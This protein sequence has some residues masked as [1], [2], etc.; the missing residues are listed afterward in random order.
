MEIQ[1]HLKQI[2]NFALIL[3][4]ISLTGCR[5]ENFVEPP[6]PFQNQELE[7]N[8]NIIILGQGNEAIRL[9][10]NRANVIQTDN[11]L[12]IKGTLFVENEKYGDMPFSTGDFELIKNSTQLEK[13]GAN[14]FYTKISGFSKVELPHEGL[15]K[16]LLMSGMPVAPLGYKKGSEFDLGAFSWPV[17]PDRYYFYYENPNNNPYNANI[18]NSSFKN[19]QKIAIDPTDPYT[20]FTCD[21][22]GTKIGDLQNVG[23]AVSTQGLIPFEP[24]VTFGGIKGF[25]GSLYFTGT[26]PLK[27][28]PVSLTGEACLAFNSDDPEGFNKFFKGD[29]ADFKLGLNGKATFDHEALDWLNVEVVLGKSTLTLDVN[30]SGKTELKFAGEREFPP[31]SPSDFLYEIIGQD[32]DFLD[33][34]SPIEQKE[35]F[36]GTIGTEL[37]DWRM[38]F[39]SESSLNLP[40]GIHLDMGKTQLELSSTEMYFLG[41][42]VVGGL[43]RVGVTGYAQKNGNFKLTG[44]GKNSLYASSGGLSIGYSLGMTVSIQFENGVFTFNG[45]FKFTGK[46]CITIAEIDFCASISISGGVTISSDGSFKICFSIGVGSLGFDVCI[47]YHRNMNV[48][49]GKEMFTQTMI[50]TEIP[51]EMVPIENRFPA[52]ECSNGIK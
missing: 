37:S 39:K 27:T 24:L 7:A 15:L 19:I 14:N 44:Y 22:E 11:G 9:K 1:N 47:N 28:Y 29:F 17:N 51:L 16:N 48:K 30:E 10:T 40:G 35:T 20:F 45:E 31:S 36:Y 43:N 6:D 52:E 23:M 21:F 2:A 33:Y 4:L 18:I 32:W 42:A 5:K 8:P 50:A 34:V 3:F 41:E 49:S 38:G 12:R 46:A 13:N 25:K 26:I